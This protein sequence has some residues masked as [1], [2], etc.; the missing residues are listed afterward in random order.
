M[1]H[2]TDHL[3]GSESIHASVVGVTGD[4][5]ASLVFLLIGLDCQCI[6]RQDA[7]SLEGRAGGRF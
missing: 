3:D 5:S 4:A 2:L 1:D 7:P 6:D